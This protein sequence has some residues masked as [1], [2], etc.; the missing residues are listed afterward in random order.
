MPV[1]HV[2]HALVAV[3]QQAVVARPD[4]A[5][6]RRRGLVGAQVGAA[7]RVEVHDL[8]RRP[9]GLRQRARVIDEAPQR[10]GAALGALHE[11]RPAPVVGVGQSFAGQLAVFQL[12]CGLDASLQGDRRGDRRLQA[13]RADSRVTQDVPAVLDIGDDPLLA[14]DAARGLQAFLFRYGLVLGLVLLQPPAGGHVDHVAVDVGVLP[15][16]AA[17]VGDAGPSRSRRRR[18]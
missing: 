17:D 16:A 13:D 10:A 3:G 9:G 12:E 4:A 5:F 15:A 18:G 7:V 11:Q 6:P 1:D 2:V 8:Q 14:L